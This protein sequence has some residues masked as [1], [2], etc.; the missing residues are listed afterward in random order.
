MVHG[1]NHP[2][3]DEY[4]NVLDIP[5]NMEVLVLEVR[6]DA[7]GLGRMTQFGQRRQ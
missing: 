2:C 6:C 5:C 4:D 3:R 7:S 1:G